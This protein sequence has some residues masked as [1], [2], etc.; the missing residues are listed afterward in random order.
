MPARNI[1]N[2][3]KYE[4][5][6][7]DNDFNLIAGFTKRDPFEKYGGGSGFALVESSYT[8]ERKEIIQLDEDVIFGGALIGHFGHFIM[9]CWSRLWYIIQ[10][11]ELQLKIMFITTTHGGYH[12]WFDD[13]FR[14]MGIDLNRIVYV[15]KPTQCRSVTVP[16]QSQ[17]N[18]WHFVKYTKEFFI[19]YQVIKSHVTPGKIKKI[20]LTRKNIIV[21]KYRRICFNEEY[22]ENFFSAHGFEVIAP[23]KLSIEEQISLVMGAD[24]IAATLGTLTHWV[25][26]CKPTTKFIML[27]RDLSAQSIQIFIN[28]AFEVND[29]YIV[30]AWKKFLYVESHVDGLFFLGANKYWQEFVADYFGE[31]IKIDD[32]ALYIGEALEKYVDFWYKKYGDSK[33]K[34]IDSLKDMCSRIIALETQTAHKRPIITYQTHVAIKGWGVWKNE[35]NLSNPIEQKHD[36]QAIKINFT[37]PFHEVYYSVYYNEKEGWSKEVTAPKMAGTTG[38]SKAIFG[39]KIRLDEEGAK[40]F[41]IFYRAHKFNGEWTT[42]AKNG[43]AIYSCG[44]KLNSIQIGLRNKN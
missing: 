35:N 10:H 31:K 27:T 21:G 4:G 12:E 33:E 3:E 41:D 19:P 7:C 24:E 13:F 20:Y 44:Q 29:Y 25:M 5:G 11:P 16:E 18:A 6:V 22:F 39:I 8:V 2:I 28:E 38:K 9:E 15:K 14:L 40:E 32:D 43:E 26:F 17:Y 30:K 36:I 34:V 1:P 23:E 37:E 42:W